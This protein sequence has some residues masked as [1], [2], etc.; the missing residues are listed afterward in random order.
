MPEISYMSIWSVA[1]WSCVFLLTRAILNMTFVRVVI[2][3]SEG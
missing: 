1:V 3:V 2:V